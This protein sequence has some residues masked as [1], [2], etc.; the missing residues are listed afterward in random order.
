[1]GAEVKKTRKE[2]TTPFARMTTEEL[3]AATAEFD[4]E[5]VVD[6]FGLFP[7]VQGLG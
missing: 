3:Q 6:E 7:P 5:M 4:R 1:M 2:E